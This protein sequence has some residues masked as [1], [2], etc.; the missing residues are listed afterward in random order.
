MEQRGRSFLVAIDL[1]LIA[2]GVAIYFACD[3][4]GLGMVAIGAVLLLF[5]L[6]PNFLSKVLGRAELMHVLFLALAVAFC[7][8][9]HSPLR[10]NGEGF[11]TDYAWGWPFAWGTKEG[12]VGYSPFWILAGFKPFTLA[13][14]A[15][16]G[17]GVGETAFRM[18]VRGRSKEAGA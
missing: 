10:S 18:S 1:L 16:I 6:K 14:D 13:F 3:P 12:D 9:Y 15:L 11:G 7:V 2:V 8:L 4:S 5:T 17:L